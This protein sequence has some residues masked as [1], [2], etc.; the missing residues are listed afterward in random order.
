[1]TIM[2]TAPKQSATVL[3]DPHGL[4][5]IEMN[6]ALKAAGLLT[7]EPG[8]YSITEEGSRYGIE[9]Y[10]QTSHRSG[11][12]AITWDPSVVSELDLSSDGK[13]QVRELADLLQHE[14]AAQRAAARAAEAAAAAP[15]VTA[16]ASGDG[17]DR[18]VVIGG[19][20]VAALAAYGIWK[21]APRIKKRWEQRRGGPTDDK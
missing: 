5:G 17:V 13:R 19:L 1:M 8:R 16:E 6:L 3:G 2:E 4:S 14:R 20:L 12:D 18:R 11:Y 21:L 15:Q 7:G 9:T 10:H